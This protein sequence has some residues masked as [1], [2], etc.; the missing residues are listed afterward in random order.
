M[1]NNLIPSSEKKA[2][3]K[4]VE[5]QL[6][7]GIT[8]KELFD[9][10]SITYQNT[11][12][13]ANIIAQ[14]P[15]LNSKLKYKKFNNILIYSLLEINVLNLLFLVLSITGLK[16][17]NI[18]PTSATPFLGL[19][20]LLNFYFMFKLFNFRGY[21]YKKSCL[22]MLGELVVFNFLGMLNILPD[23]ILLSLIKIFMFIYIIISIFVSKKLFPNYTLKGPKKSSNGNYKF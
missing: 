7:T 6:K 8:R 14:Y 3:M 17:I 5:A 18:I 2:V 4:D 15:E 1:D 19:S 16:L 22:I 23:N 12:A 13:L 20:V 21:I 9:Q 11:D 10:L